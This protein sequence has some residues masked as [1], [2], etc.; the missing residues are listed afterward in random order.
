MKAEEERSFH[1]QKEQQAPSLFALAARSKTGR[2]GLIICAASILVVI[3]MTALHEI[4]QIELPFLLLMLPGFGSVLGMQLFA[5]EA[6][7]I[8]L[9]QQTQTEDIQKQQ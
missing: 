7:R 9:Q 4:V 1:M 8:R 2:R 3:I 5:N 6:N